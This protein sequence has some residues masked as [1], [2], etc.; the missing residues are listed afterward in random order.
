MANYQ[1]YVK[2]EVLAFILFYL[3]FSYA[4]VILQNDANSNFYS[5]S[6]PSSQVSFHRNFGRPVRRNAF[7]TFNIMIEQFDLID[8]WRGFV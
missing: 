7:L 6:G 5:V 4:Q 8:V 2:L 1:L 3:R